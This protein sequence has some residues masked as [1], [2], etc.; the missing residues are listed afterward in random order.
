MCSVDIFLGLL[1][2]LFPPLPGWYPALVIFPSPLPAQLATEPQHKRDANRSILL[3]T[4]WVKTGICSADSFINIL[5]CMLGY[6]PG[7]IHAWYIIA[8]N[9]E[10][11]YDYAA[12]RDAEGAHIYVFVHENGQ[13][14][15]R[16]QRV[17]AP[18]PQ[19]NMNYGTTN[20]ASSSA[21]PAPAP[22]SQQAPHTHDAGEGSSEGPPPSYAQ[23]VAGD[24]KVQTNE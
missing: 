20:N 12:A 10:P 17:Q 15:S 18:K 16:P 8:K 13:Q 19:A 11:E 3:I 14:S 1:A 2:F 9:P 7:L 21:A 6:L 5:L 4:V 22:A 23:V 24:H